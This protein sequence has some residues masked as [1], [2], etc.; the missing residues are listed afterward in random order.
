MSW[1]SLPPEVRAVAEEHL[2][3]KQLEAWK[4]ELAYA[5]QGGGVRKI[6]MHLGVARTTASD[7]LEAAHRNLRQNGVT[8]NEFGR[9]TVR[10]QEAA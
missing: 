2:T 3:E 7:R 1:A 8:L 5:A 9:W 4:L 6:A 10:Q